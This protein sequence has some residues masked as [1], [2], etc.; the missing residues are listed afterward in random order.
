MYTPEGDGES[1]KRAFYCDKPNGCECGSPKRICPQNGFCRIEYGI[2]SWTS[3]STVLCVRADESHKWN[4]SDEDFPKDNIVF[5]EMHFGDVSEH[6]NYYDLKIPNRF[7]VCSEIGC[8]CNGM[9]LKED[10][11]CLEQRIVH[12]SGEKDPYGACEYPYQVFTHDFYEYADDGKCQIGKNIIEQICDNPKGCTCGDLTIRRGDT[13]VDKQPHC[14]TLNPNPGCICGSTKLQ[15]G[16]GCYHDNPICLEE[17]CLCHNK[18]IHRGDLCTKENVICGEYS[19]TT[20]C[21]CGKNSLR[22]GYRCYQGAQYCASDSCTCGKETIARHDECGDDDAVIVLNCDDL[23]SKEACKKG[24]MSLSLGCEEYFQYISEIISETSILDINKTLDRKLLCT[25]GTERPKPG[26]DYGCALNITTKGHGSEMT[27][28]AELAGYQCL[29]YNGCPCGEMRCNPGE[30][31]DINTANSKLFCRALDDEQNTVC[32][33][34]DIRDIFAITYASIY[35]YGCY[36]DVD[37]LNNTPGWY[38][39]K[40]EGCACGNTKCEQWQMCMK[41]GYCGKIKLDE[42]EHEALRY[43]I[44]KRIKDY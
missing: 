38:C 24:E 41:P 9:P 43:P 10:Y 23:Y 28:V 30:L 16:Y 32:G 13:C 8:D 39:T 31:C 5:S 34:Q 3:R 33:G 35:D 2:E 14:S 15:N 42:N 29:N 18:E 40:S 11:I 19:E 7:V 12:S 4:L 6:K 1:E 37:S 17:A 25:C 21:L 20:D 27:E 36:D 22:K 26:T 44:I